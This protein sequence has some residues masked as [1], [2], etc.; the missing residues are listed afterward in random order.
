MRWARKLSSSHDYWSMVGAK[1]K[2]L[3][4]D[5]IQV[6]RTTP[7]KGGNGEEVMRRWSESALSY[8][9]LVVVLQSPEV[10]LDALAKEIEEYF[11]GSDV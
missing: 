5:D 11:S 1:L 3:S 7:H 6:F 9:E 4:T 2:L 10:R 8:K